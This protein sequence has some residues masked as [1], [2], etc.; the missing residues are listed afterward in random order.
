MKNVQNVKN[1][2]IHYGNVLEQ[3]IINA[4]NVAFKYE[5]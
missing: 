3:V 1:G 4:R 5:N 2:L